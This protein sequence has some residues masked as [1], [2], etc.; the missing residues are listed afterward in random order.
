[1]APG[2]RGDHL[3][4][5]PAEGH[6]VGVL[7]ILIY[8]L[9]ID[10]LFI[11]RVLIVRTLREFERSV[12]ADSLLA[13]E[14]RDQIVRVQRLHNRGILLESFLDLTLGEGVATRNLR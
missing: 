14:T 7:L 13:A 10:Y 1:M 6:I 2:Q 8:L 11:L 3:I 12:C 9:Q 5:I 4:R